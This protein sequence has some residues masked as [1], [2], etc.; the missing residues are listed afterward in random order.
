MVLAQFPLAVLAI[1][2][3]IM[4]LMEAAFILCGVYRASDSSSSLGLRLD[5]TLMRRRTP[6]R[7]SHHLN[8]LLVGQRVLGQRPRGPGAHG[9]QHER[10]PVRDERLDGASILQQ[11]L[12]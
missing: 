10:L 2:P 5:A 11:R 1:S 12:A 6:S 7:T 9:Q 3:E 8:H 4:S